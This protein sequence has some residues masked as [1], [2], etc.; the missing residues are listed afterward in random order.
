MDNLVIIPARGGSKGI[1]GKNVK[2]IAGLPL[3]AWSIKQAQASQLVSRVLV[4]T[5]CP[6]IAEISLSHGAEVPFMRPKE[7]ASDVATTESALLHA[8]EW[9]DKNESYVPN[10]VVLLQATSP[11]RGGGVIDSA[12]QKFYQDDADSLLSV[13]EFWHFLWEGASKPLA[14]YDYMNRPRR[15]DID[16]GSIKYKE[17]GSIYITKSESLISSGN[18]LAGEI[19]MYVMDESESF[20]I[21]TPLDWLVVESIMKAKGF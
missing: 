17:N 19:S 1:P 7:L 9:L 21:D 10:N 18:R 13:C 14:L 4:S 15:Q 12:I 20:E 11:I 8:L 6:E 5:D 2:E 3:I 16:P